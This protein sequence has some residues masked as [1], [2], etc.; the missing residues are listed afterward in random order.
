MGRDDQPERAPDAPDLL[1][2][3]RVGQRVEA[4][5]ALV[6]G[7]RDAEPAH[8]AE[9]PDDV[10]REA[11]LALVLV[12]DRRDLLDHEVADRRAQQGMLGGEVEV[13]AASVAPALRAAWPRC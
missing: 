5:A 7:D 12:D 6:L 8:L 10:D 9:A 1:D 13:H 11:P 2:R 3:D 4:G